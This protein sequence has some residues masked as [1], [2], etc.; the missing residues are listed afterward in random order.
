MRAGE[1]VGRAAVNA[2][3]RV[4]DRMRVVR[5]HAEIEQ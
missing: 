3:I 4:V 2:V 5:V 1:T